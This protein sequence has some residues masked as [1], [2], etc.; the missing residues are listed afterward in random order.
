MRRVMSGR[1]QVDVVAAQ[2]LKAQHDAPQSLV[3]E[4]R[5]FAAVADL[6]VLTVH[7]QQIAV[8]EE[9]RAGAMT[10]HQRRLLAEMRV[11]GSHP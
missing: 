6:P 9:D 1:H 2:I 3:A 5:A 8:A 7:A 11:S 10:T 4:K